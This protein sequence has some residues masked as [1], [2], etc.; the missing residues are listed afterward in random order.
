VGRGGEIWPTR[1]GT[2][3]RERAGPATAHGEKQRGR[4]WDDAVSTGPTRQ[5]EREGATAPTAD[6]AGRTGRPRGRKPATG[7]LDGDSPPVTRFL[8]NG[9]AP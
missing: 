5:R 8:G 6:G 9:Q 1:A 3:G 7:G 4:A 2:C